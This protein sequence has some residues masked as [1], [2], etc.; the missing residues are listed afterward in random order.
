VLVDVR[1]L[2]RHPV[3]LYAVVGGE[4]GAMAFC[5]VLLVG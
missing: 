2:L 3:V 4:P 1:H 5:E